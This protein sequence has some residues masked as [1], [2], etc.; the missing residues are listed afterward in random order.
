[1]RCGNRGVR[2][3]GRRHGPAEYCPRR[4]CE[5]VVAVLH[6]CSGT[7]VGA[8][9]L[10]AQYLY[11]RWLR[12]VIGY[13]LRRPLIGTVAQV[14]NHHH[15]RSAIR[16]TI[17]ANIGGTIAADENRRRAFALI[18]RC[19]VDA[20]HI[21]PRHRSG[22]ITVRGNVGDQDESTALDRALQPPPRARVPG[23]TEKP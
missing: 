8:A 19:A 15:R 13:P 4:K 17:L 21:F 20:A 14:P 6:Y 1:M 9:V 7:H 18:N 22:E 23:T 5:A 12:P 2:A 16:E 10:A 3:I 11:Y